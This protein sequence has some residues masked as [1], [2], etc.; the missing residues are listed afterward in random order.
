MLSLLLNVLMLILL[1]S[2][3]A[4]SSVGVT[5]LFRL[6]F[7]QYIS[8]SLLVYF[9]LYL[10]TCVVLKWNMTLKKKAE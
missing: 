2:Q 6:L 5:A 7:I 3:E 8:V 1:C 9:P 4:I 10:L